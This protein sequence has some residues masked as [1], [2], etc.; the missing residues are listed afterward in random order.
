[1]ITLTESAKSAINRFISNADKPT[2]A[3]ASASRAAAVRG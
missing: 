2:P 3:C 1:M